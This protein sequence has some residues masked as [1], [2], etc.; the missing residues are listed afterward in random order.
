METGHVHLTV[1]H[2][3][4]FLIGLL[5][6]LQRVLLMRKGMAL[7]SD[8]VKWGSGFVFEGIQEHKLPR[9][10]EAGTAG[11]VLSCQLAQSCVGLS[12]M[13]WSP[14]LGNWLIR[15]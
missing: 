1:L 12:I 14:V 4:H 11:K 6:I 5:M 10:E 9:P 3:L 13:G 15:H 7:I 2:H 8:G